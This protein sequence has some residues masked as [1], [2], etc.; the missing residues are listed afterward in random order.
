[1]PKYVL[2]MFKRFDYARR[3]K[4]SKQISYS[5][6]IILNDQFEPDGI[7][8]NL[9]GIVIHTGS[10]LGGHYTAISNK[11]GKWVHF[12]DSRWRKVS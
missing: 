4:I 9:S 5:E 3:R 8:Y 7:E 12:N 10:L 1:M 11:G 6:R 2:F